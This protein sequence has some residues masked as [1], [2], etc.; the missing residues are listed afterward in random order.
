MAWWQDD[1]GIE[2]VQFEHKGERACVRG[3]EIYAF[4]VENYTNAQELLEKVEAHMH[5]NGCK[6]ARYYGWPKD[7]D[8]W[9][10]QKYRRP[11]KTALRGPQSWWMFKRL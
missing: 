6:T 11:P 2:R 7:V 9:Q 5:F 10:G 1:N 3:C 4:E 8:F